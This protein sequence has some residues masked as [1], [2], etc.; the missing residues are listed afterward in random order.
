MQNNFHNAEKLPLVSIITV[1]Y[2]SEIFIEKTIQSIINQNYT[3]I[4]YII[5]DGGSVDKTL[6]VIKKYERYISKWSSSKDNGIYDAMNKGIEMA[7][8]YYCWFINSGDE[9]FSE[10][11]L[12]EAFQKLDYLPDVLY[13]ETEVINYK[14]ESMGMRR[15]S[16]PERLSWKSFRYGMKVCHQSVIVK[17]AL[18]RKYE[19][20]Y[21]YSSDFDWLIDILKRSVKIYNTGLILSKFMQGG[22]TSLTIIPGLKERFRIMVKY[23]GLLH[24]IFNHIIL[25]LRLLFYYLKNKRI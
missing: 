1:V 12:F 24:T 19:L 15:H 22:Q 23:Y 17:R 9:I 18:I 21:Q 16:V 20:Q 3:N 2:N 4:E 13:G 14:G 6:E 5:V 11:V 10:T 8:G 7:T 25:G